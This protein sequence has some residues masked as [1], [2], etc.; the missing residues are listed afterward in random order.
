[1]SEEAV[2]PLGIF[3]VCAGQPEMIRMRDELLSLRE[4]I[5]HAI[6]KRVAQYLRS[7]AVVLAIME[8]TRDVVNG[9][10]GV[11]GGS[12]VSTDGTYYWRQDA[13]DYVEHYGIRIP[14]E[15]LTHA[16][17]L[18]WKSPPLT[19]ERILSIDAYLRRNIRR[20]SPPST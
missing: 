12:G 20:P 14:D 11:A 6:R 4:A 13:A 2:R 8:Y 18:G 19:P 1:M 17:H 5:P 9:A 7:G 10:F 16:E 3:G 15:F